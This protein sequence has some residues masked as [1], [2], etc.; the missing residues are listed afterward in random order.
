MGATEDTFYSL[1]VADGNEITRGVTVHWLSNLGHLNPAIGNDTVTHALRAVHN[2]LRGDEQLLASKR[3]GSSP[4][5]DFVLPAEKLIIEV[6]ETQHFT[7]DRLATLRMYPDDLDYAFDI[8]YYCHL[9]E[10]WRNRADRYRAAKTARDFPFA[11]GRRAQR[12][13]FDACRDLTASAHGFRVLRVHAPE[14]DGALAYRRFVQA[15]ERPDWSSPPESRTHWP[16]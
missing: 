10:S 12:A 13:Y 16:P 2:Q 5:L 1:A 9:V 4:R 14:C 8:E 15:L 11:G 7:S 6:D 3:S